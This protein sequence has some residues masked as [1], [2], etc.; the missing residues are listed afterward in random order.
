MATSVTLN[1]TSYSI[2]A[3]NEDNWGDEVS[4]YLIALSTGVLPKSGG[5]FTLTAEVDFGTTYGLKAAYF[6]SRGTVASTGVLRLA[7]EETIVWRNTA[8]NGN[9]VL[10]STSGD[11][12]AF[13]GNEVTT[14]ATV[15]KTEYGYLS[16][17]TS[18]IQTQIDG[19]AA[20]SHTHATSDITSG[21]FVDAR[22]AES[23]VTQHQ[24][25]LSLNATQIDANVSNTEFSYL[26]G[27]TSSIQNQINTL[28][29]GAG[30]TTDAST[31]NVTVASGTSLFHPF[32]DIQNTY[33][34]SVNG[35]L[36]SSGKLTVSSGGTL[37]VNSR[38]TVLIN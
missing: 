11:D 3:L 8:N 26:N 19:K 4:N 29:S 24:T 6:K 21:T 34:Y 37:T 25:A 17:V 10:N 15:T 5:A 2:P 27:V 18:T 36:I 20:R 7:S 23:N 38:A 32:L 16:G 12:L 22:I 13:N 31:A 30:L 35:Q 28:S 33:T 14:H 9:L 1:G